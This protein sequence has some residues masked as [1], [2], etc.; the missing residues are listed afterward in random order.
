MKT[1]GTTET[2]TKTIPAT[3]R[4][5]V[6]VNSDVPALVGFDHSVTIA[7]T[8]SVEFV[9]ERAIYKDYG[10]VDWAAGHCSIGSTNPSTTWYLPEGSTAGNFDEFILLQNP[11]STAATV[12]LTYL[13]ESTTAVTATTT[14]GATSRKTVDPSVTIP[15]GHFSTKIESTEDIVA[16]RAM[17][18]SSK[19][20]HCS[21]G[22][23]D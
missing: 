19:N 12:T 10:T 23:S 22:L 16:E 15:S 20:A 7:T 13:S 21:I 3:G 5:T 14:V 1:D 17:Y 4:A 9:A 2:A 8:N 18:W 6:D 11:G